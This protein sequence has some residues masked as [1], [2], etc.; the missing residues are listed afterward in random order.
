MTRTTINHGSLQEHTDTIT[1]TNNGGGSVA[2]NNEP[3]NAQE[4]KQVFLDEIR[5]AVHRIVS[6]QQPETLN[7]MD[8]EIHELSSSNG[9]T[10]HFC[11]INQFNDALFQPMDYRN[12]EVGDGSDSEEINGEEEIRLSNTKLKRNKAAKQMNKFLASFA[13]A[14]PFVFSANVGKNR[15][16]RK[17]PGGGPGP[18]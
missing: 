4:A 8:R 11:C 6:K 13:G 17:P 2:N 9:F 18:I 5:N 7:L 14:T 16:K 15:R 10:F 3:Q 12:D 1:G